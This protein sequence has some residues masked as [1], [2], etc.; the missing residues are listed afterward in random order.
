MGED[1]EYKYVAKIDNK[2]SKICYS[3]NGNIFKVKDMVPGINAPPM[4]QWFRSTTVPNVGNW[5]DQF[6]KE[7][8]GKYKIEVI[9][10]E[11][12]ALNSKNDEYGIKRIR[13]ARMY[14]DSVKNRDK[15]IEIK[16]IAK[17]V[18]INENTIK[19][20]YEHLFENKYLLDNG[21]KQFGPDFY[22]AQSWQR[23]RE[24]KNIK[25]MDII[26]LKHEALEHYLMN[27]Y[28][29]SYKEA[30]KLAERKYN[31]SDLIK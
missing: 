17:N 28:N 1:G 24:G 25:R 11:S 10:N 12:G 16:T 23:L 2:T 3:L 14:Y 30:H 31:Y 19:R 15:Q 26:M 21:I 20:V 7:R 4:H 27:K 22:M 13:H 6:F 5:R 18:N 29:L 9:T 8:K